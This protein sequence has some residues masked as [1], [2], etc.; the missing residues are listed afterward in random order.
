MSEYDVNAKYE[1]GEDKTKRN[2]KKGETPNFRANHSEI[3]VAVV[4]NAIRFR[5]MPVARKDLRN[6][7]ERIPTTSGYPGGKTSV[8]GSEAG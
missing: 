8:R 3:N 2:T 7:R 5:K 6:T 4:K 1:A